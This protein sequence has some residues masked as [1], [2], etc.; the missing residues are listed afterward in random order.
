MTISIITPSFNQARFLPQNLRSVACQSKPALEHI[1][2]DPGSKDGS[3]NIAKN[4]K[5]V[6]LIA[7][8][9]EGQ[10]DAICKGFAMAKGDILAWLNSDDYY[11]DDQVLQAVGERFNAP[12]KP[13]VVYG[14]VVFVDEVGKKLKDGYVN[15][16][17]A[18]LR[19]SF[20]YQVGIVQP[21]VF[22]HRRVF[23]AVGGPPLDMHYTLDYEYWVR[24]AEACFKWGHLDRIL[25]CHRWWDGM[26]TASHRV[27]S[28]YEHFD[29]CKKHFGYVHYKWA[30]RQAD[31]ILEGA[32]GVVTQAGTPTASPEQR[33]AKLKQLLREAN[34]DQDT[35]ALLKSSKNDGIRE[36]ARYMEDLGIPMEV[37]YHLE[38]AKTELQRTGYA[39][40]GDKE[41]P[42]AWRRYTARMPEGGDFYGYEVTDNFHACYDKSWL[43]A[44][45]DRSAKRLEELA[46]QRR[47]DTCIVVGNGPSLRKTDFSLFEG[48]DVIISNYATLDPGLLKRATYHTI[49]NFLVAKQ[50][51]H[52]FNRLEN[53]IKIYPYWLS[54]FLLPDERTLYLDA[55]LTPEAST[56][57]IDWISW[58]STVSFFN[59]QLSYSLGFR[60]VILVGFDHAYKQEASAREGDFIQQNEDDEN[61]FL[62]SYFKGKVW[63]AAD[64]G[65]MEKTYQMAKAAFEAV[66]REIVNCTVGGH[67]EVFRRGE[68]ASELPPG[69]K[70]FFQSTPSTNAST[71][72]KLLMIDSTP[73]GHPSATG[74]IKKVFLG[75]WPKAYFLQISL[76]KNKPVLNGTD[77]PCHTHAT[78]H[79]EIIE[80]CRSFAPEVI[81]IRPIDSPQLFEI[82]ESIMTAIRVPVV[83]HMMDDWPERLRI[84]NPERFANLAPRLESMLNSA[85]RRLS[86]SEPMSEEYKKRYGGEWTP[87]ANGADTDDYPPKKH[88]SHP[89]DPDSQT[90]VMRYMGGLADDMTYASVADTAGAVASLQNEHSIR[91]EI[92][93]MNWY[94]EKA[95][96]QLGRLPG[97]SVHTLVTEEDYKTFLTEADCLLIAYNFDKTSKSYIKFSLANK[98]PECLA[99]GTPLLAYGPADVATIQYLSESGCARIVQERNMEKLTAVIRSMIVDQESNKKM[100]EKAIGH[101]TSSLTKQSVKIRFSDIIQ[102]AASAPLK[103]ARLLPGPFT[104]EKSVHFDKTKSIDAKN[105]AIKTTPPVNNPPQGNRIRK[106]ARPRTEKWRKINHWFIPGV[107]TGIILALLASITLIY[108]QPEGMGLDRLLLLLNGI[109]LSVFFLGFALDST[110]FRKR[111]RK[112]RQDRLEEAEVT[113]RKFKDVRRTLKTERNKAINKEKLLSSKTDEIAKNIQEI[114]HTLKAEMDRAR[115]KE[116]NFSSTIDEMA[117]NIQ[118]VRR[119][120][121]AEKNETRK[122]ENLLSSKMNKMAKDIREQIEVSED[123]YLA[124]FLTKEMETASTN[125]IPMPVQNAAT[126]EKMPLRTS[127]RKKSAPV[128]VIAGMRHSGSTAL[129]N[130]VR[131]GFASMGVEALT[132]YSEKENIAREARKSSLPTIIKIH[133][134]RDDVL[135]LATVVLTTKRDLRDTVASAVRRKFF[136]LEKLNTPAEYAKYNRMLHEV[137][138]PYSDYEFTYERY[139]ANPIDVVKKILSLLNF[140][141]KNAEDITHQV[142]NLPLDQYDT[143]LLTAEHIT[144]P[145]HKLTFADT[146]S[147]ADIT[148]IELDHYAWLMRN[149]YASPSKRT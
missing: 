69:K 144:D 14:N 44:Q 105:S 46:T 101:V 11:A 43:D 61:H 6:T 85:T 23:E 116:D 17:I 138:S 22:I 108:M 145:Q 120:L 2:I 66:D 118:K 139:R 9:D 74:Q 87:L 86:I 40:P 111:I 31:C 128:V 148:R 37:P 75:D 99:S 112:I 4:A 16:N 30:E 84:Q 83:I 48:L 130:I 135:D 39:R 12:D 19:Q 141:E 95:Q 91:F 1:V 64:V 50:G 29:T 15:K 80:V 92:Y 103:T 35:L 54:H 26:K 89:S 104:R 107:S 134:M 57:A 122:K 119:A 32:D 51:S 82:A 79:E 93:T 63:Q 125:Q 62:K 59:L 42:T 146:L 106:N 131:L 114:R 97:I 53:L 34:G 5:G 71:P 126:K 102:N 94:L 110:R 58:R 67:L 70:Q 56:N 68:L 90:F 24:I 124:K 77:A 45:L 60:K 47:S 98:M 49:T 25:A 129:Y 8:P 96:F 121:E 78:S 21:G 72:I 123:S 41:K 133:E 140:D 7:E 113:S 76:N 52:Q 127:I 115:K 27:E 65:E 100:A 81:Y 3:R 20:H 132:N 38:P 147:P 142:E 28:L 55:L 149:G 73:V 109:L 36:T 18:E 137:W 143:T 136:L 33:K 13:D 117:M 88:E 10:S